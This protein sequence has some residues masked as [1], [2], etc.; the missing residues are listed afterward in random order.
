[1]ISSNDKM[2][3]NLSTI[4]I[5]V[6]QVHLNSH[7][8]NYS[9]SIYANEYRSVFGFKKGASD[10][11]VQKF[12]SVVEVGDKLTLKVKRKRNYINLWISN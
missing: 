11:D 5:T 12:F 2:D 9:Y 3:L 1:M 7:R 6:K 10:K 8:S 4:T